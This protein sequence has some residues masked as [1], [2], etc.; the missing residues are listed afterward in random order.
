MTRTKKIVLGVAA[1]FVIGG[2][3]NIPTDEPSEPS[4]VVQTAPAAPSTSTPAEPPEPTPEPS[5]APAPAPAPEPTP[6]PEPERPERPALPD[7]DHPDVGSPRL[8]ERIDALAAAGACPALAEE[9][10]RGWEASR[11]QGMTDP[12]YRLNI[13]LADYAGKRLNDVGCD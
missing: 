10:N 6:E 5:P 11:G 4:A 9:F 7:R 1:A 3:M 12:G 8:W 13:A 2:I